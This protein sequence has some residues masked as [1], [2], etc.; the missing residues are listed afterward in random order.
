MPIHIGTCFRF[1]TQMLYIYI[2]TC[3]RFYTQMRVENKTKHLHIEFIVT[4][5]NSVESQTVFQ[6]SRNG[7]NNMECSNVAHWY[8]K[9]YELEYELIKTKYNYDVPKLMLF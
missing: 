9:L 4:S 2:G 8:K 5:H 1:Y 7:Q 6:T 3:F